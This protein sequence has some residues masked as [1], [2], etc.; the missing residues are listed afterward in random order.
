MNKIEWAARC[1][2][3]SANRIVELEGEKLQMWTLGMDS[4]PRYAEVQAELEILRAGHVTEADLA[5]ARRYRAKTWRRNGVAPKN[6]WARAQ[7]TKYL[8]T[9]GVSRISARLNISDLPPLP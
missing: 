2:R 8:Q 6:P 1:V 3:N 5:E 7:Q 4:G 9:P